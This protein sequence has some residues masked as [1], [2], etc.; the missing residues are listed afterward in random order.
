MLLTGSNASPP[1]PS[2]PVRLGKI[3]FRLVTEASRENIARFMIKVAEICGWCVWACVCMRILNFFNICFGGGGDVEHI[4]YE[5][6]VFPCRNGCFLRL[7][8]W[9]WLVSD[10]VCVYV[11]CRCFRACISSISEAFV[12]FYVPDISGFH[13]YLHPTTESI[14]YPHSKQFRFANIT[15]FRWNYTL[16]AYTPIAFG[17]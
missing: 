4:N 15:Q 13:S 6:K 12:L 11:V 14:P 10:C 7:C 2:S 1:P 8:V 16:L 17:A 9:M 3:A 5:M